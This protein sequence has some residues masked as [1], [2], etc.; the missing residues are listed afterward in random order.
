[1]DI[2]YLARVFI[3]NN[4]RHYPLHESGHC[5]ACGCCLLR[6]VNIA[7]RRQHPSSTISKLTLFFKWKLH[8]KSTELFHRLFY[9]QMLSWFVWKFNG[10]QNF[11]GILRIMLLGTVC[12][13][14]SYSIFVIIQK[15]QIL[16][17]RTR[18]LVHA[19]IH[20]G[21]QM[22]SITLTF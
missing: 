11:A 13:F 3:H 7:L 14:E 9:A 22:P 19:H 16:G 1:M 20:W 6:M 4:H 21:R 10:K 12:Y 15:E 5:G 17:A 2:F 18:A 8:R